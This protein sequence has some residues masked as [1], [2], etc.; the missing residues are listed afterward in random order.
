M[1][2]VR[3]SLQK[4]ECLSC[5]WI[6]ISMDYHFLGSTKYCSF[7][8]DLKTLSHHMNHENYPCA[9]LKLRYVDFEEVQVPCYRPD[10]HPGIYKRIKVPKD[11]TEQNQM[12][13]ACKSLYEQQKFAVDHLSKYARQRSVSSG[14]NI[15]VAP[16]LAID[17]GTGPGRTH[18]INTIAIVCEN[19]M[20]QESEMPDQHFPAV[21]K[22][23]PT[24]KGAKE[25]DGMTLHSA[26]KL[27][28]DNEYHSLCVHDLLTMSNALR[29]LAIIIIDQMS[30]VSADKLYQLHQRLT[31]IKGSK[32]PFGGVSIVLCGDLLQQPPK[33]S[34]FSKIF[35][36]PKCEKYC[37]LKEFYSLWEM[38]H[39]CHI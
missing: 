23:A 3:K 32:E 11:E 38:F 17:G 5:G 24:V 34:R 12:D 15:P 22:L 13:E 6:G 26:L 28:F 31:T 7:F 2:L 39:L 14:E 21:L 10:H 29:H 16:L 1:P 25:I 20:K 30:M 27:N 36:D 9:T 4:N 18:L 8:Q 35:D 33:M 37:Q 19:L